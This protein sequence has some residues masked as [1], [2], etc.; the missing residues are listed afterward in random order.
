M[1]NIRIIGTTHR[2]NSS[3]TEKR[4]LKLHGTNQSG[5]LIVRSTVIKSHILYMIGG[6]G[7]GLGQWV[8][9]YPAM[10]SFPLRYQ[11]VF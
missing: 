8:K 6:L 11:F 5:R 1:M 9:L 4:V 7:L 10:P 3:V 2:Y